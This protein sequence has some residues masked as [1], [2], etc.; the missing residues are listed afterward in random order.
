MTSPANTLKVNLSVS[1]STIG[2][3]GTYGFILQPEYYP[4]NFDI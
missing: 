3:D 2:V 4:L 1:P